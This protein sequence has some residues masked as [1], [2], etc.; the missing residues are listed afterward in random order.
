MNAESCSSAWY[1]DIFLS[2]GILAATA[3]RSNVA[4]VIFMVG[5]GV[6]ILAIV[7]LDSDV[8]AIIGVWF[9]A[10]LIDKLCNTTTKGFMASGLQEGIIR[11][12]WLP[13]IVQ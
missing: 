10:D 13:S 3:A 11:A 9:G 8:F 5:V 12:F 4:G 6:H 1:L 7:G 2:D